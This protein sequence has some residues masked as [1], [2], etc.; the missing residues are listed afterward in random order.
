MDALQTGNLGQAEVL[1]RRLLAEQP[2]DLEG[3]YSLARIGYISGRPD[4]VI[5]AMGR[6][7]E[8]DPKDGSSYHNLGNAL[9]SKGLHDGAIAAL[10]TAIQLM[11]NLA[12]THN[13]LG[14]T[15]KDLG[16]M[17]EAVAAFHKAVA[18]NPALGVAQSNL[19]LF[20]SYQPK[21]TPEKLFKAHRRWAKGLEAPARHR[22]PPHS[23][24]R[25]PDRKLRVGYVSAD[26]RQHSVAY[27]LLPLL[28]NHD[29]QQFHLTAYSNCAVGDEITR[30]LQAYFDG[31]CGIAGAND[32]EVAARIR[33]D[34]I[35]IL[36]DLSGHTSGHRL[37][38]FARRPA[39]L[40]ITWLGY[41]GTTGLDAIDYRCSDPL[42]DRS[43]DAA[44]YSSE[45]LLQ[46]PYTNWCYSPLS[47]TP[48]VAALPALTAPGVSFGSFNNFGKI[49][50]VTLDLWAA[51]L[52]QTPSS[53]LVLKNVALGSASIVKQVQD[54]FASRGISAD[55]LEL[56][57]QSESLLE[58]L[59][60]YNDIDISL[61]TFPY[62]GTTTTCEA[63]WMGVPTITLEGP[64][65]VSRPGVSLLTNVGLAEL[66]AVNRSEYVDKAGQLAGNLTQLAELR[67]GLRQRMLDSPLMNAPGFARAMENNYR[68]IWRRWC[69]QPPQ[70]RLRGSVGSRR[71]TY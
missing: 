62:H 40:Q 65:H 39:P 24:D 41:S 22:I 1:L 35:D 12:D 2:N 45:T 15:L 30:R 10:R 3:L 61:D 51:I 8:L 11:P 31:W 33:A 67:A 71:G 55:R 13:T 20:M 38:V 63:L 28:A 42:V 21:I 66:V 32:D 37:E 70:S 47:G 43:G 4:L 16:R 46:L 9:R 59:N 26:L 57:G 34:E 23:N 17:N 53:R 56:R 29:R 18:L 36:I 6:C 44:R 7:I 54:G 5:E 48:D 58:H 14:L 27:F 25:S 60:H 49:S 19:L 69:G 64:N 68:Q 50:S 52:K